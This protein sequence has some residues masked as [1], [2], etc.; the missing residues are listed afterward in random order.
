MDT[1]LWQGDELDQSFDEEKAILRKLGT[2]MCERI[3]LVDLS[4]L[5]LKL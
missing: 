1:T 4:S 5:H 3:E 2:W